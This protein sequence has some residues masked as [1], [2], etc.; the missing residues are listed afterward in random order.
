MLS[1]LRKLSLIVILTSAITQSSFADWP[2]FRGPN[3]DAKVADAALP[4][5]WPK[6]LKEEWKV[7]VG[8]GH[9]SPIVANG[10]IYVFARQNEEE[11]L[12]SLNAATGKEIWRSSQ[13]IAYK[14]HSAAT[15]TARDRNQ[16]RW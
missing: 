3:R 12:M 11:V 1:G 8:I 4:K 5:T 14:M 16:R 6:A 15:A 13:P 10:K 7:P 2:Q 9:A